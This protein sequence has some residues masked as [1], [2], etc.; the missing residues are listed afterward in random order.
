MGGDNCCVFRSQD[1][2]WA[3]SQA[4]TGN[5]PAS[6]EPNQ[7]LKILTGHFPTSNNVNRNMLNF[8]YPVPNQIKHKKIVL[9]F[10]TLIFLRAIMYQ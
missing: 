6:Y 4:P 2:S 1:Q 8:F 3:K 10:T 5:F 9:S 7:N